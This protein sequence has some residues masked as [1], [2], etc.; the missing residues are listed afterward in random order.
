M[1]QI[2]SGVGLISGI[3]FTDLIDQLLAI[4]ARPQAIIENQNATLSA[5]QVALQAINSKLLAAKLSST[6]LLSSTTFNA[7][8]ATSSDE[9]V[10][11]A[12]STSSAIAS[13][14]KFIVDQL[15]TAQQ[16]LTKGFADLD[17]TALP[18]GKLSFEFGQARLDAD[19][20]LEK[21]NGEVGVKRGSIRI[22]DRSGTSGDIDLSKA[23]TTNDVLQ[24]I[25]TNT[26]I[27]VTA[28]VSGDN[29]V[30]TDSSGAAGNLS[31]VELNGGT[32]AAGLGI[33]GSVAA[34]TLT[35]TQVN[36][37]SSDTLLTSLND[38][39]GTRINNAQDDFQITLRDGITTVNVSLHDA[40]N[41]SLGIEATRTVG[42]VVD[43]IND[44]GGADVTASINANG[45]G[46]ML[47]DNT[48]DN[49]TAFAVT[50]LNTSLAASD[51]GI[52]QTAAAGVDTIDGTRVIASINS[53][54]TKLLQGGQGIDFSGNLQIIDRTSTTH[55]II[56]LTGV[57]SVS[58]LINQINTQT[59]G[60]VIA[61]IN[62]TGNGITLTDQTTGT[63]SLTVSGSIA[64]S[65]ALNLGGIFSEGAADSGNLQIQYITEATLLSSLNGGKGISGTKFDIRDSTGSMITVDIGQGEKTIGEVLDDI[66][67]RSPT[68][69]QARVNNNGDGILIEDVNA[70]THTFAVKVSENGS[71]TARDLGILGEASAPGSD[72][73]GSFERT[74][75]IAAVDFLTTTTLLSE[76]NGGSGVSTESGTT[77]LSFT[78]SNSTTFQVNLSNTTTIQ[79]VIDAINTASSGDVT[80]AINA[81]GTGLDLSD[82]TG[83]GGT[84]RIAAANNSKAGS[85]LGII[86]SDTDN[87]DVIQGN[88]IIEIPT[89]NSII[90]QINDAGISVNASVVNDGSSVNPFR[91]LFASTDAGTAG[92]FVFDGVAQLTAD[93]DLTDLN[94]G[95]GVD[96]AAG[97]DDLVIMTRGGNT[98]NL[99][100]DGAL[101]V[102]DIIDTIDTATGG[103]VT[104]AINSATTGLNFTD[105]SVG[106]S[107]FAVTNSL[108]S[109][110]ALDLGTLASDSDG[111]G[112]IRGGQILDHD[113]GF[114]ANTLSEA[115]DAVIFFGSD[116]PANA[117]AITSTTNRLED[118]L[119]GVT[120]DLHGTSR[121]PVTLTVGRDDSNISAQITTFV[122]NFNGVID[123]ISEHDFFDSETETRGLLLGDPT[124]GAIRNALF[125]LVSSR[126][127]DVTGQFKSLTQI[128]IT[129]GTGARLSFDSSKLTSA[130]A[131]S[132]EDVEELLTLKT[133]E[134]DSTTGKQIV[135]AE[136]IMAR[137]DTLLDRYTDSIDGTMQ[138]RV[139]AIDRQIELGNDRI[140]NLDERL[141]ARRL[142]L[143][144]EFLALERTLA[145]L[146]AQSSALLNIQPLARPTNQSNN[147][148]GSIL[149]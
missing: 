40:D 139:D 62:A 37:I 41:P 47:V 5:T 4:E 65:N 115:Q 8:T 52:L 106:V 34:N 108:F 51:L 107:T 84:F 97:Q 100:L 36:L 126:S 10:F 81:A 101:T 125:R 110:A 50:A 18:S 127:N 76:L 30:L 61:A 134:L 86:G 43:A 1:G 69:I 15:V 59:G 71:T 85:D 73:N 130:L 120:I 104:A 111:D 22:T 2:T 78:L 129:V 49:G 94:N 35:G 99:N 83:G 17:D 128:G 28:A 96:I 46:I 25:N 44:A 116:D 20:S 64:E 33:L 57:E 123:T 136:G 141:A 9:S 118:L 131:T 114:R 142:L 135:T 72:L 146:Q 92:R 67:F 13:T 31:V 88:K 124:I 105:N 24:A 93:T 80:T 144:A 55:N 148:V 140:E 23:L 87:D 21:L 137:F 143:E 145:T 147:T 132:R 16:V 12:S 113:L 48:I 42:D 95:N 38:G 32:T 19:T 91:L 149:G 79:G 29:F 74:I 82:N 27:D 68:T 14:S 53:R 75:N 122:D 103:V 3:N 60:V 133:T 109:N 70:G 6:T 77:D 90:E 54:L 89:I 26:M 112:L 56:N 7:T 39:N 102:Q 119:P 138:L 63:G 58:D 98:Y 117:V 121:S 11:T 66:N 45:T